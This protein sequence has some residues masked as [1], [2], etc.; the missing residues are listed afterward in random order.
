MYEESFHTI[1]KMGHWG[2]TTPP[3]P[4]GLGREN[5][6][7]T[8][9]LR[10]IREMKGCYYS[11]FILALEKTGIANYPRKLFM[12]KIIQICELLATLQIFSKSRFHDS[13]FIN[14]M[15]FRKNLCDL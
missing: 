3:A 15:R 8:K 7:W 12:V 9:G 10:I 14:W 6:P 5:H 4:W 1:F 2:H 13:N 11:V